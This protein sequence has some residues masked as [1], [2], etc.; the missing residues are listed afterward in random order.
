LLTVQK[1]METGSKIVRRSLVSIG[2]G[3]SL[4]V[5]NAPL[6]DRQ[7]VF[8][9]KS[10][11]R[12]L[13]AIINFNQRL[14]PDAK[15][16]FDPPEGEAENWIPPED[17]AGRGGLRRVAA[18][19]GG[20][21]GGGGEGVFEAEGVVGGESVGGNGA[22]SLFA[23]IPSWE[24]FWGYCQTQACLLPAEWYAKD[25]FEAANADQWKNKSDWRAYARRCKGWWENDGR[26][27][28]PR[29]NQPGG[30]RNGKPQIKPDHEK[31]F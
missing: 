4:G 18:L 31:G 15:P 8:C 17:A 10:R 16:K 7:L 21:G 23:E 1:Q 20:G 26:P 13:L 28:V 30:F 6:S 24:E 5:G 27:M 11:G 9:Y 22:R 19:G 29:S 14:R 12:E 2:C 3:A 25:K